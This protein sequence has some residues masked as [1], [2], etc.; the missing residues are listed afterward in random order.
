MASTNTAPSPAS[1]QVSISEDSS[2]MRRR[3]GRPPATPPWWEGLGSR[4]KTRRTNVNQYYADR[5]VV[6]LM[7]I[8]D[9]RPFEEDEFAWLRSGY[10]ARKTLLTE[11]GRIEDADEMIRVA[12]DLCQH[13]PK[14]RLAAARIRG[15]RNGKRM[16]EDGILDR[17]ARAVD[18][19]IN[20][21]PDVSFSEVIEALD[22]IR[23]VAMD[24]IALAAA[25]PAGNAETRT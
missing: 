20:D 18:G 19:Y 25:P 12:R 2:E 13:K 9:G 15:W 22:V 3:R 23:G 11:L 17:L 8:G 24:R 1:P 6:T 21:H 4:S 14:T 5:A 10:R 7:E 16:P